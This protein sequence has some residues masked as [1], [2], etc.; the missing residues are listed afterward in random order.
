M[1]RASYAL[2]SNKSNNSKT[3]QTT[4]TATIATMI[5]SNTPSKYFVCHSHWITDIKFSPS[6]KFFASSSCDRT[7]KIWNSRFKEIASFQSGPTPQ[8]I[9]FSY[10]EDMLAFC[11]TNGDIEIYEMDHF[12]RIAKLSHTL[13]ATCVKFSRDGKFIVSSGD[14]DYLPSEKGEV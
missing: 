2:F 14:K 9:E 5:Q 7:L 3:T 6:C 4:K 12:R 11:R 8:C 10:Q 1:I 13:Y